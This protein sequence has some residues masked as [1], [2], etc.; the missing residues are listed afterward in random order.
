[1][2]YVLICTLLLIRNRSRTI[3]YIYICYI[4]S[5]IYSVL[6]SMYFTTNAQQVTTYSVN[7]ALSKPFSVLTGS[8]RVQPQVMGASV[9]SLGVC[10]CVCV[11]VY[12]N[13]CACVCVCV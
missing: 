1:M 9:S 5:T 4:L 2:F 11:R 8:K 13:I 10:V 12:V 6:C 3:V 7:A